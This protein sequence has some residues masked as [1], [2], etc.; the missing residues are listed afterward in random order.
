M[1]VATVFVLSFQYRERKYYKDDR[2]LQTKS[3]H[4]KSASSSQD[5]GVNNKKETRCWMYPHI[6][7]RIVSKSF[8]KGNYYNRKV[9]SSYL[10]KTQYKKHW[11][12]SILA[13]ATCCLLKF[14]LSI[15]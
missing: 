8:K 7:V 11:E 3:K 14:L 10:L 5:N 6:R 4:S 13:E 12:Y 2:S 9:R 15:K 1:A